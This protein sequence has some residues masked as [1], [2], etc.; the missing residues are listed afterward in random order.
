MTIT[1]L[2][3]ERK[4]STKTVKC[5]VY[6]SNGIEVKTVS[7]E[8]Y[9]LT[10]VYQNVIFDGLYIEITKDV[11]DIAITIWD[12]CTPCH[13]VGTVYNDMDS[14]ELQNAALRYAQNGKGYNS[15]VAFV[16][17]LIDNKGFIKNL[18]IYI[19]S[20]HGEF[21]LLQVAK[22]A[23]AEYLTE[24]KRQ[25]A[26]EKAQ[27]AAEKTARE[28][29]EQE[30]K[31]RLNAEKLVFLEGY[32]DGKTQI[33]IER[34]YNILSKI[35]G[36]KDNG[37]I[38]YKTRKQFIFDELN[39]GGRVEKK[40]DII[41]YYGSKWDKKQSKPKTEYRLYSSDNSFWTITKTEY[42]FALYLMHKAA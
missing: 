23:K 41:S 30:E 33:Q 8:L 16:K 6:K 4:I 25:D 13:D 1:E 27:R 39:E 35:Q 5:A 12:D 36:Y 19:I 3:K 11:N 9:S 18:Y 31:E 38:I 24:Q 2:I 40:E 34:L 21:E 37:K 20:L 14:D 42:D 10:E 29:A 28:K 7:K 17:K 15:L 22:Q 32:A 26:K